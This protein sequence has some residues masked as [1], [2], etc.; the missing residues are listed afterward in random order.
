[1]KYV[2]SILLLIFAF[3]LK[4]QDLEKNIVYVN[5]GK[6]EVNGNLLGNSFE[7]GLS[8]HIISGLYG[9]AKFS[10]T[11]GSQSINDLINGSIIVS[12]YNEIGN[13][14]Y[15]NSPQ[16]GGDGKINLDSTPGSIISINTYTAGLLK[17][18]RLGDKII[19]AG[20]IATSYSKVNYQY[21]DGISFDENNILLNENLYPVYEKYSSIGAKVTLAFQYFIADHLSLSASANYNS[22]PQLIMLNL[23]AKTWF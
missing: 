2:I 10:K 9:I 17:H 23:G 13:H 16:Q 4:A 5:I 18:I 3:Q 6:G 12:D 7:L 11:S 21:L 20:T 19:L 14:I 1:M 8:R 22:A 15:I